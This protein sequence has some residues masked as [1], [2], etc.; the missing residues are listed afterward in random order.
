MSSPLRLRAP[1]PHEYFSAL[2]AEDAGLNLLEA[3]ASL[4]QDEDPGLDVQAVIHEVDALSARLHR[5]LAPDAA[6]LHRLRMLKHFLHDEMGFAGNANNFYDAGNSYLH[7]VLATRR[8]IPITLAVIYLELAGA[9]GLRAQGI[10]FPGHFLLRLHLP[11]GDVVLDPLTG[12][13]LSRE[14]LEEAL[15][16]Y[17]AQGSG[18]IGALPLEQLLRPAT[19]RQIL[20][21]MLRNLK[22]VHRSHGHWERLLRVQQRLVLLLPQD[23]A[24][25]L[26]LAGVEEMLGLWGLA[27]GDLERYLA[28]APDAGDRLEVLARLAGLRG[29]S[30]PSLH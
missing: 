5:R 2:V 8:G 15:L 16:P 7:Q 29:R 18:E 19:P 4:A 13:S 26:E 20:A 14:D 30:G 3:A 17:R 23:A 24:E 1:T 9:I 27:C 21:R 22:E 25:R 12:D 28:L 10:G 6:P 11:Q